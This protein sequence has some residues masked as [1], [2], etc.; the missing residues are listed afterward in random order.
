M[1]H[2]TSADTALSSMFDLCFL[3][4]YA[5]S[6]GCACRIINQYNFD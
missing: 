4:V 3:E 6:V 5:R 1:C 2:E